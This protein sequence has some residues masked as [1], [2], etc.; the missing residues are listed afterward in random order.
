MNMADTGQFLR[1]LANI[2]IQ[3]GLAE[4]KLRINAPK[5]ALTADLRDELKARKIE[6]LDYLRISAG[7][8]SVVKLPPLHAAPRTDHV[9]L[10]FEQQRFW[11]LQQLTP[12]GNAYNVPKTVVLKT[13]IATLQ[14]AMTELVVRHEILRTVFDTHDGEPIQIILPPAPVQLA[15]KDLSHFKGDE[16]SGAIMK[17][18]LD[19]GLDPID[20]ARW[21]VWNCIALSLGHGFSALVISIHHIASDGWS[22]N[23]LAGELRQLC[24]AIDDHANIELPPLPVQYADYAIWQHQWMHGEALEQRLAYWRQKLQGMPSELELQTDFPRPAIQTYNGAIDCLDLPDTIY[25]GLKDICRCQ[26]ATLF[27]TMLAVYKVLLY[28][29]TGQTDIV[30]G[31]PIAGRV[32][33]EISNVQGL[34]INNLVLR[35]DLS[36]N[37]SFLDVIERVRCTTLESYDHSDLPFEKLVE[38]LHPRRDLSHNPIYQVFFNKQTLPPR[39]DEF[40]EL[41]LDSGLDLLAE[42][43]THAQFDLSLHMQEKQD[44]ITLVLNYNVDLFRPQTI[45]RMAGHLLR[46]LESIVASPQQGI[47][48]LQIM[49]DDERQQLLYEWNRNEVQL[50]A[51]PTSRLFEAQVV[52]SPDKIALEFEQHCVSY[53]ELNSQANRLARYLVNIGV[54]TDVRVGVCVERGVDMLVSIL[55]IHKAGG[56]YVPLDPAYPKDRLAYMLDDSASAILISQLHLSDVLPE[57]NARVIDLDA[58]RSVIMQLDDSNLDTAP[59]IS[60]LVY[61]IYTSGSTGKPKGVAIEQRGLVNLLRSMEQSPGLNRDDVFCAV[62]TLSF[63]IHASELF[64]PLICGAKIVMASREVAA[65][66]VALARLLEQGQ[67]T[68]MQ[69][70]PATWRMLVSSGWQGSS[71]LTI[72]SGG[73]VLTRELADQLLARS[74]AVWNS[75]GPTETTVW[76]SVYKIEHGKAPVLI[77]YPI[78][79]TRVYIVDPYMQPVPVGIAGELLIGGDG[80]ARGYWNRPELNAERF[81]ADPF[82]NTA[83]QRVYRTGDKVRRC[84][85]GNIEYIARLDNQVKLRGFRIELGEVETVLLRQHG[86]EDAVALVREDIPGDQRLVAYLIVRPDESIDEVELRKSVMTFLPAYMVPSLFVF[87]EAFQLTPS[88]KVDRK[89]LPLPVLKQRSNRSYIKPETE[90]EKTLAAIWCEV[91]NLERVSLDDNFFD[92]GGHSLIAIK[93]IIQFREKTGRVLE[94]L[95][96]YQQTLGQLAASVDDTVPDKS[97]AVSASVIKLEPTFFGSHDRRLFGLTRIAQEPRG[98]GIVLCHSFAHE[99]SRCH[100]AMREL[101]LRLARE[102]FH[103]FSFDYYGTG[104]SAGEYHEARL[105]QWQQDL[106]SAIDTFRQFTGLD[107]VCLLGMRLGG[108]L[109]MMTAEKRVDVDVIALWDPIISGAEIADEL[110]EIA[111]FQSL[112]VVHQRD[113]ERSDVLAYQLSKEMKHDMESIDLCK[114]KQIHARHMLVLESDTKS[115]GRQLA[116][117]LGTAHT[118]A[119]YDCVPESRV[120][121]REPFESIVPQQMIAAL[122]NWVSGVY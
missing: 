51:L 48:D 30:V 106:E 33:H 58:D 104:D 47:A 100:R 65:D 107:S 3:I 79:N 40:R 29:Y 49:R 1:S 77:G 23:M 12:A 115:H 80:V 34:F 54:A 105:D 95:N 113:I 25:Q 69:A 70:T 57:H 63:D 10:S 39:S 50:P 20:L 37:P 32:Q 6:I 44:A 110:D 73:E 2:G 17:A 121:M 26:R 15:Q 18:A 72:W 64:L 22:L 8:T 5:D 85:D 60:D 55:A 42:I 27:M 67:V 16:I 93:S 114:M 103:V 90:I 13:S 11:F 83:G 45:K 92:I 4:D 46:L 14:Q 112:A 101:G 71:R 59:G 88:G 21:P 87:V 118:S 82:V 9:P 75:Y 74:K 53:T 35:T 96:Y 94:P 117:Q 56:A 28:R 24:R 81:I 76:S 66:G 52:H 98:S 109:A 108:T 7:E 111:R 84:A 68:T 36:A 78:A 122:V 62:T 97:D 86:V 91:L 120:W 61:M 43:E 41:G 99:Y 116:K 38:E 89:S 19:L 119:E 31:S 102:G